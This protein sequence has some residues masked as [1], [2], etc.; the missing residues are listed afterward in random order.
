MH[1]VCSPARGWQGHC[2]LSGQCKLAVIKASLGRTST[3]SDTCHIA[4]LAA[5]TLHAWSSC[6]GRSHSTCVRA[7]WVCSDLLDATRGSRLERSLVDTG[8]ALSASAMHAWPGKRSRSVQLVTGSVVCGAAA[9]WPCK[10]STLLD[11][12]CMHRSVM[13]LA[14]STVL[15]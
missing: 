14:G 11:V 6:K 13:T 9:G 2:C 15:C 4:S 12:Y 8:A 7:C 10:S 3:L 5:A 1:H